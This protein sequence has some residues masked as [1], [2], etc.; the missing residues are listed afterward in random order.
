MEHQADTV[1]R[2]TAGGFEVITPSPEVAIN[3]AHSDGLLGIAG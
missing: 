2:R 3:R 1:C